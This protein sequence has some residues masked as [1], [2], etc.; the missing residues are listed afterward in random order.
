M[1]WSE[2]QEIWIL[3]DKQAGLMG[4]ILCSWRLT[5]ETSWQ[6][7]FCMTRS[8]PSSTHT[9][10][11]L[12]S[13]AAQQERGDTSALLRGQER[14]SRKARSS[15]LPSAPS[16]PGP[17]NTIWSPEEWAKRLWSESGFICCCLFFLKQLYFRE[18]EYIFTNTCCYQCNRHVLMC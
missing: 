12:Q 17:T 18:Q 16:N 6:R 13:P 11:P 4:V 15:P 1:K 8:I 10:R 9:N 2:T 14:P 3:Q 7:S 5:M